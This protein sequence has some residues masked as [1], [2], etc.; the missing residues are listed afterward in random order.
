MQHT[1]SQPVFERYLTEDEERTLFRCVRQY[2]DIYARRDAAWMQL[3]RNTGIRVGTL[4]RLLVQ[5]ASQALRE[6]RLRLRAEICKRKRGYD[7]PLNTKATAALRTLLAIRME[8]GFINR[9]E[10]RLVCSRNH[11]GLSVRSY[12]SRMQFW[13][14]RAGLPVA[15]S[16]HWF[17]HTV[18]QRILER[19]TA[20]EPLRVVQG[21]LNHANLSS[22]G[23][24]TRPNREQ[25]REA[26]ESIA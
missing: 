3:L 22:T 24:Y 2:A 25:V 26:M 16:P 9:P 1:Q 6:H 17:R 21:A 7:I 14:E 4:A 15:A 18:A 20:R 12:Q 10:D 8:M 13:R 11:R 19:S 5:D 23:I